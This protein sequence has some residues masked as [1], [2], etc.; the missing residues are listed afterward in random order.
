MSR[1]A[2][3]NCNYSIVSDLAVV[4]FPASRCSV[5]ES[6]KFFILDV[7]E[8]CFVAMN[9]QTLDKRVKR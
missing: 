5:P 6:R 9:G 1:C 2:G 7:V 4:I 8:Q 3:L